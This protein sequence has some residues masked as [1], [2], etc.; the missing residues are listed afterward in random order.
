MTILLG[1]GGGA[2][3]VRRLGAWP[4]FHAGIAAA[5]LAAATW[6]W[7][8]SHSPSLPVAIVGIATLLASFG[9]GCASV[10][11]MTAAMD[12][13]RRRHQA[14]TDMTMVQSSRDFGE[15]AASSVFIALAAQLGYAQGF[16]L[17]LAL[18]ALTLC[19]ALPMLGVRRKKHHA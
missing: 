16:L 6:A 15:M 8:A 1:C 19:A 13:T 17:G 7:L 12:F 3:L 18:A 9:A 2:W 5:G 14:G 4:A 10:A 11:I